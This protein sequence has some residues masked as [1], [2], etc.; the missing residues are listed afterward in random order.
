M[1]WLLVRPQVLFLLLGNA[2]LYRPLS[3]L[4]NELLQILFKLLRLRQS[5]LIQILFNIR[6]FQRSHRLLSQIFLA[7]LDQIFWVLVKQIH[8]T[9]PIQHCTCEWTLFFLL[10]RSVKN[11]QDRFCVQLRLDEDSQHIFG[12]LAHQTVFRTGPDVHYFFQRDHQM[13][14]EI[15]EKRLLSFGLFLLVLWF[16]LVLNYRFGDLL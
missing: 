5:T 1:Q 7:L 6:L 3:Q 4:L 12:H 14:L 8:I 16:L 13:F 10:F 15:V 2:S 9:E 11:V